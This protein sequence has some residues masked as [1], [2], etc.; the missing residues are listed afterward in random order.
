MIA[1]TL[2]NEAESQR[3]ISL[4]MMNAINNLIAIQPY[5]AWQQL[6]VLILNVFVSTCFLNEMGLK[7]KWKN[8]VHVPQFGQSFWADRNMKMVL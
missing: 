5:N 7:K 2:L 3:V 8:S 6:R 4:T 1:A